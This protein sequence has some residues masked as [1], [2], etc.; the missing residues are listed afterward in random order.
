VAGPSKLFR[1]FEAPSSTPRREARIG[2]LDA[3]RA[4][5]MLLG[6][7]LHA[8]ISYMT[9]RVP[10][11]IWVIQDRDASPFFDLL[12]WWL[13]SF[14]LPLFFFL[15]GFF[16]ALV[17]DNRGLR[18]LLA[19]RSRRLLVPL[20]VAS[21]VI[22]PVSYY[23]WACGWLV[24]GHCTVKQILAV[25]F[26]SGIQRELL[27]PLHLWFLEDLFLLTLAWCAVSWALRGRLMDWTFICSDSV[28]AIANCWRKLALP[29]RLAVPTFFILAAKLEAV[30]EHHNASI[31]DGWRLL[32]YGAYFVPGAL[33]Y[34]RREELHTI[35]RH[36]A[37][38]LPSAGLAGA[39]M[40]V[41]LRLYQDG[42]SNLG[43]LL[44]LMFSLTAWFSLFGIIGMALSWLKDQRPVLRY[45]ADASYWVYLVHLPIVGLI[46]L[47]LEGAPVPVCLKYALVVML[48]LILSL[49]SYHIWVRYTPIGAWLHG[50][51]R[52]VQHK[53]RQDERRLAA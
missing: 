13:H 46:Q 24:S 11:L 14:R 45:L 50:P 15:A 39:A 7:L 53:K 51:R 18:G 21:V 33:V 2:A 6:V 28:H 49:A 32:Y 10:G 31:P 4:G 23:I 9:L 38:Y 47:D 34:R 52:R 12:F 44:A 35:F 30:A 42:H 27:G 40:L 41:L 25:K 20:A 48:T 1:P 5:A 16:T 3:V 19:Q 43:A 36:W 17:E 26:D 8:A 29:L 37:V 22:L